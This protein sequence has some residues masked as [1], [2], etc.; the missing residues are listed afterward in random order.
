MSTRGTTYWDEPEPMD[1]VAQ[2]RP[3]CP[4]CMTANCG[5]PTGERIEDLRA[6]H[7]D[8]MGRE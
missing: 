7:Y 4:E 3:W 1:W 6:M 5:C 2:S 8:G